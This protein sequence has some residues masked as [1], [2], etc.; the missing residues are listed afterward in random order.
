M[1]LQKYCKKKKIIFFSSVFDLKSLEYLESINFP[2]YKIASF[3][4]ND[5]NLIEQISKKKTNN[6][7]YRDGIFNEI[8]NAFSAIKKITRKK[9]CIIKMH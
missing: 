4:N 1:P 5:L 3:E 8:K 7:V 2:A 6:N 9:Y